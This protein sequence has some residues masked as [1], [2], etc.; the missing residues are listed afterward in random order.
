MSNSTIEGGRIPSLNEQAARWR[1]DFPLLQRTV[2][3]GKRLIYLDNAATSQKPQSVIDAIDAYYR[4]QNS[5]V[6][7]ALH[8]LAGEAT[9]AYEGAR[10]KVANFVGAPSPSQVVFTRGTTESINLVAA[11]WGR[12]HL[13]AGDEVLVSEM[14]H[15]SNLI[16]WQRVTA[17]RGA[18]LRRIPVRDDGVLDLA[19]YH[20]LLGPKVKLVAIT[21]MSNLLGT[22][23]PIREMVA[24]AHAC[25]AAVLVDGAQSVPHLPVNVQELD[26]DFLAFSGHKMVGPTGIGALVAKPERFEEMDPYMSGGEMILKVTWESATW[27]DVPHRFE[28]GTPNIAGAVGLGA[29]IDYLQGCGIDRLRAHEQQ[30]TGYAL[31]KLSA[32]AGITMYGEAEERGGAVS[33][34][35][36][37]IHPHDVAQ[38][39][40][41]DGVAIRAGHMCVQP[42]VKKLGL[43]ALNRASLY[44]YNTTS[45]VDQLVVSLQRAQEFFGHGNG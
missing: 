16:P 43:S 29:A 35:V 37:G 5:N 36:N 11:G 21:H 1:D 41:Q 32:M 27:A 44:L 18:V 38:F 24:A 12:K 6:H 20:D 45:D 33:F 8:Q 34:N 2:H 39:V 10:G 17:E 22:I 7:R 40:D 30:L 13:R 4:L 25:G 19:A 14:E 31:E 42:L 15:H 9:A 28:A 23:N 3:D 26:C